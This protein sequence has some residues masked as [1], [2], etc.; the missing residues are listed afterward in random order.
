MLREGQRIMHEAFQI[1][2]TEK[3]KKDA[4]NMSI[5]QRQSVMALVQSKRVNS[6][7]TAHRK[8]VIS[9]HSS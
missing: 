7:G 8:S 3:V 6:V 4:M 2:A 1:I 9:N 5:N